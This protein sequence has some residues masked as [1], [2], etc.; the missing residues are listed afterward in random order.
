VSEEVF[1]FERGGITANRRAPCNYRAGKSHGTADCE[2]SI[3][4]L[5][6]SALSRN[7]EQKLGEY[8]RRIK[9][10]LGK[11]EGI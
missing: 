9:A 6:A 5:A 2:A 10:R 8:C 11:A 7:S 4:R 3:L 1:G